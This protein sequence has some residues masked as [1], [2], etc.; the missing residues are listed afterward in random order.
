M[1]YA[2][3]Q[4]GVPPWGVHLQ[5]GGV[6]RGRG[7]SRGRGLGAGGQG[8]FQSS[9][10]KLQYHMVLRPKGTSHSNTRS[11][12]HKVEPGHV[13][14]GICI[15]P[16]E[17]R[18]PNGCFIWC[19]PAWRIWS[20]LSV[21]RSVMTEEE[22]LDLWVGRVY[23]SPEERRSSIEECVVRA[24]CVRA[25]V[26][27][28]VHVCVPACVWICGCVCVRACVRVHVCACVCVDLWV[29]VCA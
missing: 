19:D 8:T 12:H 18:D 24:V 23:A 11:V 7:S 14:N 15:S 25:C 17:T 22:I 2:V 29:R 27:V 6:A 28:R 10:H 16:V 20:C 13:V 5:Q 4:G 21:S 9:C 1:L 3:H 26:C